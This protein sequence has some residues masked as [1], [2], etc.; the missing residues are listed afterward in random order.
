[1]PDAGKNQLVSK[2][3]KRVAFFSTIGYIGK[4]TRKQSQN[5]SY[6]VFLSRLSVTPIF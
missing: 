1:M 4:T 3:P 6:A 2:F 5:L